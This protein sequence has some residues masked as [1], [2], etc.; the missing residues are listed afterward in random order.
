MNKIYIPG[1]LIVEG[2][3]D[4]A[5]ISNLYESIFVITNGYE[6]PKEEI[7]FLKAIKEDTQVIVMTD[8]DKAGDEIR[9][10]L[11]SIRDNYIN[12]RLEAPTNAKKKGIA[13]C[14]IKDIQNALDKYTST[15]EKEIDYDFYKL[16]LMG[17]NN[18]KKLRRY[19]CE[20]FNL[21]LCSLSDMKKRLN[22]LKIKEE[23]IKEKLDN[24]FSR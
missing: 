8:A 21:G 10:R 3:H 14:D 12:I 17:Q 7:K 2:T 19:L 5:K 16:G 22:L 23:E 1:I 20:E 24:A 9:V 18:S 6:I 13:E 11:N 15:K 4:K